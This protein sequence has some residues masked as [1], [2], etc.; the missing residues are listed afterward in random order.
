MAV[1]TIQT[2]Y[3]TILLVLVAYCVN[4]CVWAGSNV[5]EIRDISGTTTV[6]VEP[7]TKRIHDAKIMTSFWVQIYIQPGEAR[8][9][10]RCFSLAVA[11]R[12]LRG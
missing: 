7:S 8:Q 12:P 9:N 10:D 11:I 6:R 3:I 5:Q 1:H 4:E 2:R